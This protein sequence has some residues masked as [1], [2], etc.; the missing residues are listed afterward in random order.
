MISIEQFDIATHGFACHS[1]GTEKPATCAGYIL[2]SPDAI[3]WRLAVAF[4]KFDPSKV[5]DGGH[6][7]HENYRAMAE[8]NGVAS[9]DPVLDGCP[10][11]GEAP[12]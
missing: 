3:G 11:H 4:G 5:S 9:D 6:E 12:T 8:A 7:L 1:S 10:H 2:R